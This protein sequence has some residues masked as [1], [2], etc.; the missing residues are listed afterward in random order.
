MQY[1]YAVLEVGVI[2]TDRND[3]S[4]IF[5]TREEARNFKRL[6]NAETEYCDPLPV[7]YILRFCPDCVIS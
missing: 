7:F 3:L 5:G 2:N 6:L 4:N 1:L